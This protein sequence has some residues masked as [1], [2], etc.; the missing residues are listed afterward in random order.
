MHSAVVCCAGLLRAGPSV[1]NRWHGTRT[2]T[3]QVVRRR[4]Q[5]CRRRGRRSRGAPRMRCDAMRCVFRYMMP[6]TGRSPLR[7][8]VQKD[9]QTMALPLSVVVVG[10][11]S[12]GGNVE[13]WRGGRKTWAERDQGALG[14]GGSG[15]RIVYAVEASDAGVWL[16]TRDCGCCGGGGGRAGGGFSLL[17]RWFSQCLSSWGGLLPGPFVCVSPGNG[18]LRCVVPSW[19]VLGRRGVWS[20]CVSFSLKGCA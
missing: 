6:K 5:V 7:A 14:R 20:W 11:G 19:V 8:G 16:G 18:V 1:A 17:G 4:R 3:R 15:M 13:T 2:T 12:L 10:G 9:R